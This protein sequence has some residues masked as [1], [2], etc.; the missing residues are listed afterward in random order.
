MIA[1]VK[2]LHI[3]ALCVWSAGLIGLPLVLARHAPGDDQA[4]FARLREVTHRAYTGVVTPA[5]VIAIAL[6]TALI[7]M[8][9]VFE[10]WMFAKLVGVG[11]LVLL[12]AWIGHI[13][14]IVGERQGTYDPP[15]GWPLMTISVATLAG[16]VILLLVLGKPLLSESLVPDWLVQPQDQPLPLREVPVD[17]VPS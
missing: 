13:T 3:A 2:F 5:A 9:G 15:R 12:H 6:G 7:F 8:R 14:L 16:V 10:P 1:L 11:V 4:E 17:E